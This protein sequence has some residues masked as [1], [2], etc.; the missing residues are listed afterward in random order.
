MDRPCPEWFPV[1]TIVM[2]RRTGK[3]GVVTQ[4]CSFAPG[5]TGFLVQVDFQKDLNPGM[6]GRFGLMNVSPFLLSKV[7]D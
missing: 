2:L 5:Q 3:H 4:N 1:G 6:R 7:E